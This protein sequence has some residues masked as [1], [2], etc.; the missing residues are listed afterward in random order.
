VAFEK[1]A[2]KE[3]KALEP[4]RIPD[5]RYD[6]IGGLD[7]QIDEIREA[8]EHPFLYRRIYKEYGLR[9]R[10][11]ILLHGPP[12]CGKTMVAK[13]IA[14][15]LSQE[16]RQ[17]LAWNVEALELYLESN[18]S[19]AAMA[20]RFLA[21]HGRLRAAD[22]PALPDNAPQSSDECKKAVSEYLTDQ[23]IDLGKSGRRAGTAPQKRG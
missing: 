14:N 3:K 5:A 16:I 6:Q 20:A 21:W 8:I 1:L 12:G 23:Q 2:E 4:E 17:R 13:A 10:K 15:S 11:G 9:R 18:L 7:S 19:D 22:R